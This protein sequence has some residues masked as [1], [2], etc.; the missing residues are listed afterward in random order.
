VAAVN[1]TGFERDCADPD[2]AGL[3]FWGQ[4]FICDPFGEIIAEAAIDTEE[5]LY[6]ECDPAAQ[7]EIRRNWPFLRDRRIDAYQPITNR[8]ID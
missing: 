5:T 6:A 2:A 3:Q 7:E 8:I 1:R 4:S